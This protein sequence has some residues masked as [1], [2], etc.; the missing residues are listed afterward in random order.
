VLRSCSVPGAGVRRSVQPGRN[1]EH[2]TE[3]ERSSEHREARR[4]GIPVLSRA[5]RL[6]RRADAGGLI[7]RAVQSDRSARRH[8][9]LCRKD[10]LNSCTA[11]ERSDAYA[12]RSGVER[13][14]RRL[15]GQARPRLPVRR[16][17]KS[18]SPAAVLTVCRRLGQSARQPAIVS[19]TKCWVRRRK[20][21]LQARFIDFADRAAHRSRAS[22]L[23]RRADAAD[24][25]VID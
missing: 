3:H 14:V 6:A 15:A 8:C 19:V 21:R 7:A 4:H 9:V 13:R 24:C 16:R 2:R 23:A 10:A 1:A 5:S 17:G 22:R 20:E 11:C 12:P 18:G 25:P